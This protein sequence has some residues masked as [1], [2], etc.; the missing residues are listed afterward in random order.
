MHTTD[1]ASVACVTRGEGHTYT[2]S[3]SSHLSCRIPER[4]QHGRELPDHFMY[5]DATKRPTSAHA[6]EGGVEGVQGVVDVGGGRV[7]SQREADRR[8]GRGALQAEGR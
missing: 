2:A 4:L 8:G 3:T 7:C 1:L 5:W 6:L